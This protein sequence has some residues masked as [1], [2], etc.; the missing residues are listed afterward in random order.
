MIKPHEFSKN[1]VF[2]SRFKPLTALARQPPIAQPNKLN[3]DLGEL[4]LLGGNLLA[5]GKPVE[6]IDCY[7]QVVCLAPQEAGAYV[8]LGYAQ[9]EANRV[10]AAQKSFLQALTIDDQS[11]DAYFL[12]GQ[13]LVRQNLPQQALQSFKTALMKK[14]NFD[15]GWYELAQVHLSVADLDGALN[16]YTKA[17]ALSPEFTNAVIGKVKVLL[18]LERWQDALDA[19]YKSLLDEHYMLRIYKALALQRL[20]RNDEALLVIENVLLTQ[21]NSVEALQVR[22]TVLAALGNHE[23]ALP[24]YLRAI[25]LDPHFA[26]ALS[27]AGAI[28]AKNGAFEQAT[29]LYA[30]AIKA[31][32]DHADALYNFCTAY[33]HMGQCREAISLADSGLA[34]HPNHADMHWVKA[35]ALL[36]SGDFDQ[37]WQEYEWRWQAKFLGS[38]TVVPLCS[39]PMWS[40]QPIYGKTIW[41]QAEQGLGDTIQLLRYIPLLAAKGANVLLTVQDPIVPLCRALQGYCLLLQPNQKIPLFDF[42]CPLFSLPLAF[43]TVLLNIPAEVPYLNW[44]PDLQTVWKKK[45]GANSLPKIGLV[46]SGNSAFQNDER[47]SVALSILTSVL[48][49]NFCYVSLQQEVRQSDKEA[50]AQSDILDVSHELTNFAETAALI[51]CMD[52]I[53]SVDTSVAHLAGA[54]AKPLWILLPYSPDWRWLMQ[55]DSSPWYPTAR[56]FRQSINKSWHPVALKVAA[57]LGKFG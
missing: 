12:L 28:Y 24:C 42:Y 56:L 43:K 34:Y 57:E 45:L 2:F 48:P 19:V 10:S 54:L 31:Q 53:I 39:Q 47:R 13:S 6:A 29:A 9:L 36:R 5:S 20:K 51:G 52:L 15:F 55:V 16:A 33:L 30:R 46:W 40:G 14:P 7:Q 4:K 3:S 1:L 18:A 11:V 17:V 23:A 22:G 32:P 44:E 37:G 41:V 21:P 25:D 38:T 26:S 50:L 35:A 49:R 27:D 8:A